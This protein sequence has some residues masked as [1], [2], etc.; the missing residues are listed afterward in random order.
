[1]PDDSVL[2]LNGRMGNAVHA[3]ADTKPGCVGTRIRPVGA[4]DPRFRHGTLHRFRL[5]ASFAHVFS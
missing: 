4:I 1:M 2:G 3:E 5:V